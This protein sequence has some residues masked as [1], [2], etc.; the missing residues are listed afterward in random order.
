MIDKATCLPKMDSGL[1]TCDAYCK[2]VVGDYQFKTRVVR[3]SLD[4][5]FKQSFRIAISGPKNEDFPMDI[6][7]SVWD[8][9]KWNEDDHMGDTEITVNTKEMSS[10][11]YNKPYTVMQPKDPAKPDQALPLQNSKKE[12]SQ[13][14]LRFRYMQKIAE[15]DDE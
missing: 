3:N 1:G 4:P 11:K 14:H 12:N 15:D 7:F 2:I 9:D 5:E 8:W 6:K 13:L 10:T